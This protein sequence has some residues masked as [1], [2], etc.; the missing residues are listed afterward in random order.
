MF[1]TYI[2]MR[3]DTGAVF[4][5]GKGQGARAQS[6]GR[7]KH[8]HNIV[9]KHGHTV[10]VIEHFDDEADAFAHERYLIASFRALGVALCNFTDGG[11]GSSGWVPSAE[12]RAQMSSSHK[13][14]VHSAEHR[15]KIGAA[16]N[17][18]T[19][20]LGHTHTI[21]AKAKMS[22]AHKGVPKSSAHRAKIS[23]ANKGKTNFLGHTHTT[24]T[25][26]K[27]SAALKGNTYALGHSHSHSPE[28]RTK[29]S[30]ARKLFWAKQHGN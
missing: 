15:A 9:K 28:A 26:A 4:Y 17:G 27:M 29:M 5:V 23:T 12:T 7:S 25:L 2:H 10:S 20:F 30:T 22:T 16:A 8:W 19:N 3:N 1:Y 24:E 6:A 21:E 11:E 13:G 18:H 14:H